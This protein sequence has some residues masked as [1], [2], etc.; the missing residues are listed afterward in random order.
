MNLSPAWK[1]SRRSVQI[2][3]KC[4]TLQR[5][6][7]EWTDIGW[8][9]SLLSVQPTDDG[10]KYTDVLNEH[11]SRYV[12]NSTYVSSI[13]HAWDETDS[14]FTL[15][16]LDLS[17]VSRNSYLRELGVPPRTNKNHRLIENINN[18]KTCCEY[19][20]LIKNKH[21]RKKVKSATSPDIA[22]PIPEPL[23]TKAP[24]GQSGLVDTRC[25]ERM[26]STNA[27][28]ESCWLT[29]TQ[30][31]HEETKSSRSPGRK[32][33][34]MSH[35]TRTAPIGNRTLRFVRTRSIESRKRLYAMG[36]WYFL[37]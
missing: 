25:E 1:A 34:S 8:A 18:P 27:K 7:E 4:S 12:W 20:C 29:V 5:G 15:K 21:V 19:H 26:C 16:V 30:P 31:L 10:L 17:L 22:R 23:M 6:H 36:R 14:T 9:E 37:M 3:W 24:S 32:Y 2:L 13:W 28:Y 35:L 33:S 11:K